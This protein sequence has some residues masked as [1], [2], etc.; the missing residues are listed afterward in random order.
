MKRIFGD[1]FYV[2][3]QCHNIPNDERDDAKGYL[4]EQNTYKRIIELAKQT[5]CQMIPTNDSHYVRKEDR[6]LLSL[7]KS[8]CYYK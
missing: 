1:N 7:Y 8:I 3:I 2:E 6:D 5:G 4:N